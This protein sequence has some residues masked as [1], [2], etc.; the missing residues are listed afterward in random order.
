M[1]LLSKKRS[2]FYRQYSLQKDN[3]ENNYVIYYIQ[4][5][6]ES[7]KLY[8]YISLF[9]VIIRNKIANY[10]N[11]YFPCWYLNNSNF[12]QNIMHS[13]HQKFIRIAN[14]RV[15]DNSKI[16]DENS[17]I[18]ELTFGFWCTLFKDNYVESIW[19][20]FTTVRWFISIFI[21][22]AS[23]KILFLWGKWL[24]PK[25]EYKENPTKLSKFLRY[26]MAIVLVFI[27]V[28]FWEFLLSNF[29]EFIRGI[30]DK[31]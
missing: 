13:D 28:N 14:E 17:V 23:Y 19:H 7:A 18:S 3:T 6:K 4:N 26:I 24:L 15:L 1:E 9:E 16:L 22:L 25:V 10:L 8:S 12:N 29:W 21:L 31:Q 2:S 27:F 20:R 30:Y 11:Q 5:I